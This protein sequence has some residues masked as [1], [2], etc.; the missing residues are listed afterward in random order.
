MLRPVDISAIWNRMEPAAR[1]ILI[2]PTQNSPEDILLACNTKKA[3]ALD[4]K[5]GVLI[6]SIKIHLKTKEKE[7]HC[8][9]CNAVVD[10][11]GSFERVLPDV[12]KMAKELGC[13]NVIFDSSRM[14][15]LKAARKAGFVI[16]NVEWARPV[17]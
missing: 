12:N 1:R 16:R 5:D 15:W 9:W 8:R 14:G 13:A 10:E 4:C 6:V 2:D 3:I 11:P 17:Q 7:L